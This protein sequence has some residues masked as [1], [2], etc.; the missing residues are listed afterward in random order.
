MSRSISVKNALLSP[1][2]LIRKLLTMD[3]T[4][5]LPNAARFMRP[6]PKQFRKIVAEKTAKPSWRIR[7]RGEFLVQSVGLVLA[8]ASTT[9]ATYMISNEDRQPE[10]AGLE[11]LAIFSRPA[12]ATHQREI[13]ERQFAANGQPNVDYTPVGS[14]SPLRRS[15]SARGFVVLGASSGIAVVQGPKAIVRVSPG[16]PLDGL[17]RVIAIERRDDKWVVV[18]SSGLI[19]SN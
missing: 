16:D 5:P 17:G 12:S 6:G 19:V 9:F 2:V 11:H 4:M 7:D 18:T 14:I 13:T 8:I 1:V 15:V 10:F 3:R